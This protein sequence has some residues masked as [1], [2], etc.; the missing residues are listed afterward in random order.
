M[1]VWERGFA[2][3]PGISA[4]LAQQLRFIVRWKTGNKLVNAHGELKKAREIR[5]GKR[6]GDHRMI[7]DCRRCDRKTGVVF[8]P[9]HLPHT[10]APLWLLVSRPGHGRSP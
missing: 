2:G 1:H 6:S 7:F 4:A 9:V 10:P 5:R 3:E 8:L